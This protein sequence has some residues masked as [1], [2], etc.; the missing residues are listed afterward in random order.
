MPLAWTPRAE[1]G[2]TFLARRAG[3]GDVV[4]TIG[5]GDVDR[6]APLVLEELS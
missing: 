2:A 1:D 4:L 5:A 3:P 6:V